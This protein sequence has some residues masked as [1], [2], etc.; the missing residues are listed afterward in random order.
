MKQHHMHWFAMLL[1]A[2]VVAGTPRTTLAGP[3]SSDNLL[4][5]AG[6]SGPAVG[7]GFGVPRLQWQSIAP[8]PALAGSTTMDSPT[9]ADLERSRALSFDV[10]LGWPGADPPMGFEPYAVMGPAL[11]VDSP[12]ETSGMFGAA[13]D[14]HLRLGA[15][16][17]AGFNWRVRRDV[18]LFGSYDVTTTPFEGASPLGLRAPAASSPTSY[19][20]LYGIRFRY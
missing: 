17:G 12:Y 15:R 5:L 2:L 4:E 7:L 10:K 19:D 6:K 13:G 20:A 8:L 1:L 18:T 3:S 11:F 16:V 14:P 9:S